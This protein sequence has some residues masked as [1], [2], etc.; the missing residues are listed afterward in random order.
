MILA[1]CAAVCWKQQAVKLLWWKFFIIILILR[2]FFSFLGKFSIQLWILWFIKVTKSIVF[3][4]NSLISWRQ[5]RSE[6][7]IAIVMD[8]KL[9]FCFFNIF[10]KTNILCCLLSKLLTDLLVNRLTSS[11]FRTESVHRY[12]VVYHQMLVHH[13]DLISSLPIFMLYRGPNLWVLI[14]KCVGG[15][16]NFEYLLI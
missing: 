2:F 16:E 5:V 14:V 1:A 6:V 15:F 11:V 13:P 4:Y 8:Q 12:I 3:M 9:N 7:S 10:L